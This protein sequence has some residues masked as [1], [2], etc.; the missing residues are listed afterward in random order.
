[1]GFSWGLLQVLFLIL[2]LAPSAEKPFSLTSS[3]CPFR[4]RWGVK[5]KKSKK[6]WRCEKGGLASWDRDARAGLASAEYDSPPFGRPGYAAQVEILG[7]R[8]PPKMASA[9]PLRLRRREGQPLLKISPHRPPIHQPPNLPVRDSVSPQVNGDLQT[10]S[11]RGRR[12][13]M[14]CSPTSQAPAPPR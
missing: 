13:P 5:K 11:L 2:M 3:R 6:S 9:S 7:C 4:R 14:A 1:M 10:T 8:L 12:L